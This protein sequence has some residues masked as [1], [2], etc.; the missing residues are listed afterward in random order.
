ME[1]H[2]HDVELIWEMEGEKIREKEVFI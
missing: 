1:P 2:Q